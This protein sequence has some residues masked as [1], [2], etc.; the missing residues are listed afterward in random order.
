MDEVKLIEIKED[1]HADN[2]EVAERLRRELAEQK[3][4][5]LNLMSSPGSGKTL[6]IIRTIE[7]LKDTFHFA[8]VE[9]DIDSKI[10]AE[11]VAERGIAAIQLKTGGFCHLDASMVS[12][13]LRE[14]DFGRFDVVFNSTPARS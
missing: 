8:V 7:A 9:A 1:I 3:T 10:D 12:S 5:L 11:K 4:F 14:I 13:G 6:T 2:R